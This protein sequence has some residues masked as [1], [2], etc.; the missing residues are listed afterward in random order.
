MTASSFHVTALLQVA[1]DITD[2][3]IILVL[4]PFFL[5]PGTASAVLPDVEA[6][7]TLIPFGASDVSGLASAEL[8]TAV[9][10][11][12]YSRERIGK[13]SDELRIG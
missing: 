4:L 9:I 5:V 3:A 12:R 13:I 6:A 7:F 1:I 8:W 2:S 11:S 10:T